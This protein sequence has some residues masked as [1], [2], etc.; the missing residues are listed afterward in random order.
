MKRALTLLISTLPII[1]CSNLVLAKELMPKF[2]SSTPLAGKI[3]D[4]NNRHFITEEQL[5]SD[6]AQSDWV[7]LGENH[8][9]HDHHRIEKNLIETISYLGKLGNV[10]LEMAN[11]DQQQALDQQRNNPDVSAEDLNWSRGWPWSWYADV[12]RSAL[13]HANKV[14][15]ADL[16]REQQMQAYMD[17]EIELPNGPYRDFMDEIL[18]ESHCGKLPNS[19][20]ANML[21]V[22]I[23]RDTAMGGVLIENSTKKLDIYIAGTM[24]TR[25]DTGVTRVANLNST[26]ILMV[27]AGPESDPAKYI[28]ESF[29]PEPIAD[30]IIFTPETEP[31]DHCEKI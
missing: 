2:D 15:G 30:Y 27:A 12:V 17:N 20:L 10:A 1:M 22:Q 7:L 16:A 24:H 23:A 3:W 19:Q 13:I 9:N 28:P 14:I 29:Q 4:L 18:Y 31:V 8:E 5:V 25:Y 6:I 11:Q 26:T 21:R